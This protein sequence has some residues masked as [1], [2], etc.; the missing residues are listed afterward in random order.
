MTSFLQRNGAG[1]LLIA[2]T[3][4]Y[5]LIFAQFSLLELLKGDLVDLVKAM[6]AAMA[7]GGIA[8]SLLTPQLLRRFGPVLCLRVALAGCAVMSGLAVPVHFGVGYFLISIGVGLG[9]G[10][11]T[12][13]LTA[14]LRVFLSPGSWGLAIGTGTGLAYACANLPPV[15]ASSPESQSWLA[16]AALLLV[17]PAVGSLKKETTPDLP[18]PISGGLSLPVAILMFLALVWLDSAAFFI[19]QQT[20]VLKA[21]SW[22]S[23]HLWRN[24]VV[25]FS[26]ALLAGYLLQR[27]RVTLVV[28]VSF[29]LLAVASLCLDHPET[30]LA[31]GWLYPA[32]VSLYSTAL[33]ACPAFLIQRQSPHATAFAAALIYSIAGWF[34][35]ANGIG[36]A[37]NLNRIPVAFLVIAGVVLAGPHLWYFLKCRGAETVVM[38]GLGGVAFCFSSSPGESSHKSPGGRQV[39]LSEGCIHCHS[40]YVRPDSPD[41]VKWGP[42]VSLEKLLTD[43]PVTIGNR[44]AGPDLL[45]VGN[46]RS[47]AWLRQHF[48]DPQSLSPGSSMPSYRHLFEDND[49]RGERLIEFLAGRGRESLG[50]RFETIR[51][52]EPTSYEEADGRSLF[53]R[54]CAACHGDEGR[55]NGPLAD[56]WSKRPA[57]LREGP[58]VYSGA[59]QGP[60]NLTLARIIKFGIPGTDMSGH[61]SLGDAEVVALAKWVK[62]LR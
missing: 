40:R 6:M 39:Y 35:S 17:L 24:A 29:F 34:G 8:G 47:G 30:A 11:L 42:V 20:P 25:H 10:V 13:A 55:G 48:I 28:V 32:G 3:Y 38:L 56:R 16:T 9:L 59:Q 60:P 43:A 14:N 19:I 22:G 15:F 57:N 58:F 50:G 54:H 2:G 12:V 1:V 26:F 62:S 46:R 21:S 53:G 31:G 51:S 27:Q 61:E 7:V 18:A 52:W 49:P 36:M 44:R 45:N 23:S 4:F 41:V 33:V 37:E 5:F